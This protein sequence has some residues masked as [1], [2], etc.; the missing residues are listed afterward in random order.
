MALLY[1]EQNLGLLLFL[2]NESRGID[3][4]NLVVVILAF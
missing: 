4:T 3:L 1:S 2:T